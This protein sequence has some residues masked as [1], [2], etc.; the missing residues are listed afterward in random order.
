M[1]S[2]FHLTCV[3]QGSSSCSVSDNYCL[4]QQSSNTIPLAVLSWRLSNIAPEN[5]LWNGTISCI[6]VACTRRNMSSVHYLWFVLSQGSRISVNRRGRDIFNSL[7]LS[8]AIW[9]QRSGSKLLQVIDWCLQAPNHYVNQ[10]LFVIK[11]VLCI[12]LRVIPE[13]VLMNVIRNMFRKITTTSSGPNELTCPL[14]GWDRTHVMWDNA[15]TT[16]ADFLSI[17][18]I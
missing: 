11:S 3:E 16:H 9:C 7:W 1:K 4:E 5:Q 12:H 18:P 2:Y 14:I 13:E 6:G 10:F 15:E 17:V 8:D